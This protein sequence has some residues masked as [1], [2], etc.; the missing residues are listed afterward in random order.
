[1]GADFNSL[2]GFHDCLENND[3]VDLGA[4]GYKF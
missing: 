3:L 2:K 4:E 1:M